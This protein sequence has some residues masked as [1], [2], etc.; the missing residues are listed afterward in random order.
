MYDNLVDQL[1][2]F[3]KGVSCGDP[4]DPKTV[5]GPVSRKN[6]STE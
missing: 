6:S 3:S 4:L 1:T 2:T 5:M